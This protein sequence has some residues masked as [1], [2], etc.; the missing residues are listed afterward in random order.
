MGLVGEPV[1]DSL[2]QPGVGKDLWPLR[3]RQVG[4]DDHGGLFGPVGDDLEE[5]FGGHL[6]QRDIAE[7]VDDDQI[8]AGP[9]LEHASE[10]LFALRFDELVDQRGGGGKANAF[11]LAAGGDGQPR[12]QMGFS[13]T[14]L[15]DQ[16]HRLGAFKVPAL[17]QGSDARSRDVRRLREV[18]LF[19][20]FD[21][22]QMR[23]L[24]AQFNRAPLAVF[25]LALQQSLQV[26]QMRVLLLG[27]FLGQRCKLG[28]DRRQMQ[29]LA[30]LGDACGLPCDTR[31]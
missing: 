31:P 19:Q 10:A 15:A 25:D 2:A 3:E 24:E 4:G 8:H 27:R 16:Q 23:V 1:E 29:R 6:G 11:S 13:G 18:E 7:F 30:V 26:M 20:R 5:Q 28:C 14:G 21:P 9:A 12:C 17:G 22:R